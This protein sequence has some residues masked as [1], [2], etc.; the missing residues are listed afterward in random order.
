MTWNIRYANKGDETAGHGWPQRRAGVFNLVKTNAPDVLCVQEALASQMDELT[1][2][3]TDYDH[4]GVGRDDA[5]RAGEFA[6]VFYKRDRF[7]RVETQ[8]VWLSQTPDVPSRGWDAVLPRIATR[9]RLRDR[10]SNTTFDAWSTHFDHMGIQARLESANLLR[11]RVA[12]ATVATLVAGDL[13]TEPGTLG[14]PAMIA[15]NTLR[16]ARMVS[17]STPTGSTGTFCGWGHP[18]KASGPIDYVFVSA[19]VRVEQYDVSMRGYEQ[20]PNLSDHLPVVADLLLP[21]AATP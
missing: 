17:E 19:T 7:E 20:M 5:K 6:A 8:T 11:S 15:Q 3:L 4:F 21:T 1:Q 2:A 16:D 14:Y 10:A 9:V 13:N 12:G 18:L